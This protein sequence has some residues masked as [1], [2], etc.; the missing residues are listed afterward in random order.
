VNKTALLVPV[1]GCFYGVAREELEL[2]IG[3]IASQDS[4]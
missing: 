3:E 4:Q 1:F 2:A